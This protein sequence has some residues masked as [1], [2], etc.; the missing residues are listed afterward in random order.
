M[1]SVR[2]L[3]H[4]GRGGVVGCVG[5]ILERIRSGSVRGWRFARLMHGGGAEGWQSGTVLVTC[6]GRSSDDSVVSDE[7][8]SSAPVRT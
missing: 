8:W 7:C 1:W 3:G 6:V 4:L 2:K 5:A